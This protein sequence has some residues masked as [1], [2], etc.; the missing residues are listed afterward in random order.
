MGSCVQRPKRTLAQKDNKGEQQS[1]QEI[2][3]NIQVRRLKQPLP[4]TRK[5]SEM[6]EI[7]CSSIQDKSKSKADIDLINIALSKHFIFTNLTEEQR[8]LVIHHMKFYI[9]EPR[10][11]VVQQ[12]AAGSVFFV[13]SNGILEVL[14]DGKRVNILRPQESFGELTLIQETPRTATVSTLESSS[15]WGIDRRTFRSTLEQ[16]NAQNY[17]ENL[18]LL[19]SIP[20][21]KTLNHGQMESLISSITTVMFSSGQIIVNQ[22]ESGDL[23][24]LIKEGTVKCS[25]DGIEIKRQE[26][27]DY[28]G[29]QALLYNSVRT[30]TV[31][32]IEHTRCLIIGRTQL[33]EAFGTSLQLIIQKNSQRIAFDRNSFLK[34]LTKM[35]A[36][37]LMNC[38]EIIQ[39]KDEEIVITAGDLKSNF[40]IIVLK[41]ELKNRDGEIAFGVFEVIGIREIIDKVNDNFIES[42][43][44]SG[45]VDLAIISNESFIK[46]IGGDFNSVTAN[47]D[48]IKL[49]KKVPLF[50]HLGEIQFESLIKVL[51]TEIYNH[52]DMI[53][54]QNE[55]GESFFLIKS[56]KVDVLI[57]GQVVRSIT[58]DDYFGERALILDKIRS[59]TV[60]ANGEVTCWVLYNRDFS[61]ILDERLKTLF[62][63]RIELQDDNIQ[64]NDL[65]IVNSIGKGTLGNVFLVVHKQ[66]KTLYALKCVDRR[67]IEAYEIEEN[68]I[69]EKKIML[70]IDHVLISKLIKTFKDSKRLYFLLELIRG[71]NLGEVLV[72]LDVLSVADAKFYTACIFLM[73]E[74]LHERDIIY[75][76]LKPENLVVDDEG[77][78]KLVDFGAAKFIRGRTYTIV[79]A[80]HYNAPEIIS[81]HGYTV[82]AD[83]WSVGILLYEFLYAKVPFGDDETDP[84]MIYEVV[85][86]GKL[87]FPVGSDNKDNVK[88]LLTQLLNKNAAVRLGGSFDNLKAH[89]WFIGINWE[90]IL[91]KELPTPYIP[92]LPSIT[93]QVNA[94]LRENKAMDDVIMKIEKDEIIPKARRVQSRIA[95]NW[96][97]YFTNA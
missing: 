41:G 95:K 33:T 32:A 40:L 85:Q 12:G 54:A 80:P 83:Y 46:A 94:A 11:L 34:K 64:I 62:L 86:K 43:F 61:A 2:K 88:D 59:A 49:L 79:G 55:P 60:R 35:Q 82:S 70:Q 63:K 28:F 71:M 29:E 30:A 3:S 44:A 38:S 72:K 52:N 39:K 74:H 18:R 14:V 15:L 19:E 97:D 91:R 45:E 7:A 92:I 93:N 73:L 56:G 81:G 5:G 6:E 96:D 50:R 26:K 8:D 36:E 22:G 78:P 65:Q 57:N 51:K 69:L 4:E 89:A 20:V 77:Y 90:K 84:Y 27:G 24:Y 23:L 13:I 58:K 67:K 66:K 87:S 25:K 47:N 16:I 37:A 42:Y 53:F 1:L 76:D 21:F 68:L 48:V 31:M 10:Q 17:H 75:R 9:F